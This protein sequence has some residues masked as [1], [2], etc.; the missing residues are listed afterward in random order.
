MERHESEIF[1][2]PSSGALFASGRGG[3]EVHGDDYQYSTRYSNYQ[4]PGST[5]VVA[6]S[7]PTATGHSSPREST[8]STSGRGSGSGSG[9][10]TVA[11][12]GVGAGAPSVFTRGSLMDRDIEV[13][14]FQGGSVP[15]EKP[16]QYKGRYRVSCRRRIDGGGGNS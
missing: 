9:G 8:Y 3:S 12:V 15:E 4:Y 11:A 7:V 1:R 6:G 10:A 16:R 14:P 5:S 13:T 2:A